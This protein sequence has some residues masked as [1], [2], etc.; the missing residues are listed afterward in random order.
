MPLMICAALAAAVMLVQSP[1]V[2]VKDARSPAEQKINSQVLYEI[3]RVRGQAAQKHV[4]PG[5]TGVRIDR[6]KRALVDVRAIVTPKLEETVRRLG[7]TI[8]SVSVTYHSIVA[9]VPLRQ[10]ERLARDPAVHAIEP[11]AEP[12]RNTGKH[13]GS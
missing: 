2:Q 1:A 8:L 12:A 5:P 7:G 11:N 3:Y 10:L 6:H 9:W 13:L 4:P